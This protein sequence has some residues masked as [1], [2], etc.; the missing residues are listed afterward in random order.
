VYDG[1]QVTLL[2]KAGQTFDFNTRCAHAPTYTISVNGNRSPIYDPSD[3]YKPP[4]RAKVPD[5]KS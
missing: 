4:I 2:D 5:C 3:P 1:I